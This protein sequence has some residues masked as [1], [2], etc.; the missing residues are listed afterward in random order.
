MLKLTFMIP[1]LVTVAFAVQ[2]V[3]ATLQ[4]LTVSLAR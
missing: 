3:A 1:A 2:Y 4:M